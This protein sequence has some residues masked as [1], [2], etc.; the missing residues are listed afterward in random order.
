METVT[1][2][3]VYC[4][5][6]GDLWALDPADGS[7]RWSVTDGNAMVTDDGRVYVWRETLRA[8][9]AEDGTIDWQ[10]DDVTPVRTDPVV[11]DG[12]VFGMN[13]PGRFTR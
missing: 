9:D 1:E 7:E 4:R 10:Y 2:R 12:A 13:R 6:E 8:I 11:A 3:N 5:I